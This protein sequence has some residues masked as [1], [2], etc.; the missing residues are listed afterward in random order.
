MCVAQEGPTGVL[1]HPG[2]PG[3]R[4]ATRRWFLSR[5]ALFV[6]AGCQVVACGQSSAGHSVGHYPSYYPDEIRIEVL[7]PTNAA[8]GLVDKSLH[9][10]V[11]TNPSFAGPLPDHVRAVTSLGSFLIVSLNTELPR[12]ASREARCIAVHDVLAVIRGQETTGF[13]FHPY[14]I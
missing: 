10:Y 3:A 1:E 11:G 13:V 5:G 9:A 12:F 14:P 4:N 8:N 2:S 6:L 7:D